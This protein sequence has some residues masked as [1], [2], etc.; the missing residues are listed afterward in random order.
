MLIKAQKQEEV[1]GGGILVTKLK[2]T[3]PSAPRGL[4][5]RYVGM[6]HMDNLPSHLCGTCCWSR[7]VWIV[8]DDVM[9]G[10]KFLEELS[11]IAGVSLFFVWRLF[12]CRF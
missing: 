6:M 10:N 1:G 9:P 3:I 4:C 5:A 7:Y 11:H 2:V 12:S 8:D